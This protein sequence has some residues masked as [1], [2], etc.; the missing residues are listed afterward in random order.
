MSV[1]FSIGLKE[2]CQTDQECD[3]MLEYFID[4]A[5][6]YND[7]IKNLKIKRVDKKYHTEFEVSF[8]LTENVLNTYEDA[9]IIAEGIAD[10]VRQEK[11]VGYL[12]EG[13]FEYNSRKRCKNGSR[14]KKGVCVPYKT[15]EKL[16]RCPNGSRR[17]KKTKGCDPYPA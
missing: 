7:E 14:K 13:S 1:K 12:I 3:E 6:V 4:H 11:A 8:Q 16:G 2:D 10:P 5:W 15:G 17:N 9:L